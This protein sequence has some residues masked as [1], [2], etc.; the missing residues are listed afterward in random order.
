MNEL[1]EKLAKLMAPLF[2]E[3]P[4]S[5]SMGSLLPKSRAPE[6][7]YKIAES[8]ES[9]LPTAE[10]RAG[11]WLYVDDID[12]S[13]KICQDISN[14]VGAFWHGVVHRREGDFGNSKYWFHQAGRLPFSIPGYDPARLVDAVSAARGNELATLVALQRKEWMEMFTYCANEAAQEKQ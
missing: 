7:V 9:G 4:L 11:L 1:P 5:A 8:V 6:K 14:T 3:H 12:R 13:H 2:K 10:L